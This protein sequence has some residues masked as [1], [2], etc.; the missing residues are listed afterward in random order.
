MPTNIVQ[1]NPNK[2]PTPNR[3]WQVLSYHIVPGEALTLEQLQALDGQLL[4]S[5]LEGDVGLLKVGGAGTQSGRRGAVGGLE[6]RPV[7]AIL[8]ESAGLRLAFPLKLLAGRTMGHCCPPPASLHPLGRTRAGSS[9]LAAG[10][11]TQLLF[12]AV[13]QRS[14]AAQLRHTAQQLGAGRWDP[15]FSRFLSLASLAGWVCCSPT[16]D[17]ASADQLLFTSLPPCRVRSACTACGACN[18]PGPP[19]RPAAL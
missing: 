10:A 11:G 1:T 12:P 16:G 15:F 2:P 3:T 7:A 14:T 8:T 5:M 4:Q 17:G 18:P 13:H 6:R 19:P 9:G